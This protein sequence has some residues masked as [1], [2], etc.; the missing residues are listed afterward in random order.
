MMSAKNPRSL[1]RTENYTQKHIFRDHPDS[2]AGD[3]LE[4]VTGED[5]WLERHGSGVT[6]SPPGS[7]LPARLC[8]TL[9]N[10]DTLRGGSIVLLQASDPAPLSSVY[11]Q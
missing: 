5:T 11:L 7:R 4:S 9:C 1:K 8:H 6:R 2:V 3:F 10:M